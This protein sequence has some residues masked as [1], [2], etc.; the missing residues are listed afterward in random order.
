[1]LCFITPEPLTFSVLGLPDELP[2]PAIGRRR[3]FVCTQCGGRRVSLSPDWRPRRLNR[4]LTFGMKWQFRLST[5]TSRSR[6]TS[7]EPC[8]R[9]RSPL[10]R[11]APAGPFI[12]FKLAKPERQFR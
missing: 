9:Q 1:M 8:M 2:C 5:I 6:G 12:S 10:P 3:K 4:P 11:S 7:A